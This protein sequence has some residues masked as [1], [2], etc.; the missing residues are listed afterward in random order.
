VCMDARMNE[1]YW[2]VYA[3]A[4]DGAIA[5]AGEEHV[6]AAA[7]VTADGIDAVAGTGFRAYPDLMARYSGV[8]ALPVALPH[9]RDIAMLALPAFRAGEAAPATQAKPVYLRDQ[10]THVKTG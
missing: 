1:V 4:A 10:V 5:L 6:S 9:A 7:L 2:G 8:P 3:V